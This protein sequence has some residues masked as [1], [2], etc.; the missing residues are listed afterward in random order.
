MNNAKIKALL[1]NDN[2][3]DAWV[4]A[5]VDHHK[6][7]NDAA[8]S[9]PRAFLRHDGTVDIGGHYKGT[10]YSESEMFRNGWEEELTSEFREKF[11]DEVVLALTHET[12]EETATVTTPSVEEILEAIREELIPS[13]HE[14]ALVIWSIESES[15]RVEFARFVRASDYVIIK[16][17]DAV[18]AQQA[19]K[20]EE[21]VENLDLAGCIARWSERF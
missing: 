2:Y 10:W 9:T 21:L 19:G 15:F 4:K 20:L 7:T 8:P 13:S 6:E 11:A 12:D 3:R 5:C 17:A 14:D 18:D 16:R 1:Q